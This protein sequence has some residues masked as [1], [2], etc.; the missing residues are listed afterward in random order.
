MT[1]QEIFQGYVNMEPE[2]L[3]QNAQYNSAIVLEYLNANVEK[4]DDAAAMYLALISTYIGADGSVDQLEYK[5]CKAVFGFPGSYDDFFN[6]VNASST[7]KMVE[8]VDNVIDSSPDD[9]KAAFVALGAAFCAAN[10]TMT[11]AEQQL[12]M[13]YLY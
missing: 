9:V 10:G 6:M 13:K 1:L 2:E 7:S 12:L 5:F 8:L 11:V 4:S 3:V